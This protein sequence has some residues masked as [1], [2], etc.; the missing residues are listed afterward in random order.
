M[1]SGRLEASDA[2]VWNNQ[3][4]PRGTRQR[5][6]LPLMWESPGSHSSAGSLL[7]FSRQDALPSTI[8]PR[9]GLTHTL[10]V[11]VAGRPLS[12]PEDP[13]SQ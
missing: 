5:D 13:T 10:T 8:R 9:W 12:S 7:S 4:F 11:S 3:S 6:A 2:Q 1:G